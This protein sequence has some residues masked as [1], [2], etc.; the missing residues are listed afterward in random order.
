MKASC[1]EAIIIDTSSQDPSGDLSYGEGRT[2]FEGLLLCWRGG[3]AVVDD[4]G[5][6]AILDLSDL[7]T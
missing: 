3:F 6:R 1:P 4:N 5:G 7:L 2:G